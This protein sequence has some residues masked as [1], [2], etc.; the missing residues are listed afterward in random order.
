MHEP[1]WLTWARELQAIAQTGLTYA[2]D[3]YDIER[4]QAIRGLA[5]QMMA[6]GSDTDAQ[7]IAVLFE[8]EAG[9]ATPKIDV[10]AAVFRGNEILLVKE[11]TDGKWS[12]PGGWGDVNQS[13]SDCIVREVEEESGFRVRATKLAAVYDRAKHP[14]TPPM[15]FYCYKMFFL[16]DLIGGEAR[17]S[18]ETTDVDFFA[19]DALPDLSV[20][21]VL[22]YQIARMFEHR[23]KPDLPTDFD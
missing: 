2:K 18:I 19:A 15:P 1:T 4:Y 21:R 23:R 12:L 20:G 11:E 17:T 9:Y 8:R 14:H 22:D 13:A 16:C 7:T 6:A 5:S 10:R 3:K